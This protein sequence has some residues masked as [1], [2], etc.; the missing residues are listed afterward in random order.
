MKTSHLKILHCDNHILVV[1]KP[2]CVPIV[3]DSSDDVSLLDMAKAWVK[4][5]FSKPGAVF[6][7]VVHRLDRPVSGVVVFARTS[8]AAS[9]LSE[10]W[11]CHDIEKVYWGLSESPAPQERKGE[12]EQWLWKDTKRNV[13]RRF[14]RE[15]RQDGAKLAQTSWRVLS[16]KPGNTLLELIP[17]TGRSHQ[18]RVAC[19]SM[20]CVL[21]GDLKYGARQPLPD[22]SIALH[23]RRL[24]F[25]HPTLKE[26]MRF[27]SPCPF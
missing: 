16:A 21:K 9:R 11:R 19:A 20:G 22:K 12:I 2:A 23:A 7:G 4:E 15:G 5:E 6:L 18:L 27:E 8:K 13:V 14:T 10:A 26:K 25:A 17:H 1:D 24:S 3:P